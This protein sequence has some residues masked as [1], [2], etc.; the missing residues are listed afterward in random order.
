MSTGTFTLYA[1]VEEHLTRGVLQ[2]HADPIKLVL[3][4]SAHTPSDLTHAALA[5]VIANEIAAGN[6]YT[7]GGLSVTGGSIVRAGAVTTF[8]C[9][10]IPISASGGNIPAWRYAVMYANVTRNGVTNPLIGRILGDNTPADVP[11]LASGS[12][13]IVRIN[14]SGVFTL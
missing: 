10:N 11:L 6:G 3:L 4:S 8:S 13:L 9:D 1:A 7:A 14:A 12:T 2:L 5:D